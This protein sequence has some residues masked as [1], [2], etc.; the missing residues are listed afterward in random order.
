MQIS[1]RQNFRL[2][3]TNEYT[4]FD[5]PIQVT[6]SIPAESKRPSCEA[7]NNTMLNQS[8]LDASANNFTRI[9]GTPIQ[10]NTGKVSGKDGIGGAGML[11]WRT[12]IHVIWI[13]AF[14]LL[15][16]L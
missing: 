11:D 6:N 1:I 10:E 8:T 9:A 16:M 7:L 13:G 3:G 4:I 14:G 12:S 5:L 2:N 15:F